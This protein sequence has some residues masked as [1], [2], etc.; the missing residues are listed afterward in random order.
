MVDVRNPVW[1][2]AAL[3]L[4]AL[5]SGCKKKD[6]KPEEVPVPARN[7]A[8]LDVVSTEIGSGL[9][10]R[11]DA[12]PTSVRWE[13]TVVLDDDRAV[14]LG[15]EHDQVWM[16]R[17]ADRGRTWTSAT[18]DVKGWSAWGIAPSGG[19]ALV[20][21]DPTR[22]AAAAGRSVAGAAPPK[23]GPIAAATFWLAGATDRSLDG[24][25]VFFPDDGKLGGVV[26]P[27]ALAA[28][29]A[30]EDG[31]GLLAERNKL[32]TIAY[33][34]RAGTPPDP[35][36][37]DKQAYVPVPYGRP[38]SLL[39]VTRSAVELRPFPR[40]GESLGGATALP[41]YR[42][43]GATFA[44]LSEGPSCEAGAFAFRRLRGAPPWLVGVSGERA[45]AFKLPP[46][47]VAR[48]G[49]ATNAV[50]TET[51]VLDPSDAEKKRKV[52]QLVRCTL[53]GTCAEPK[54]PPF[55]IWSEKHDR[56]IWSVPTSG[57][58]VAV[59]RA[60][61]G[62]RWGLY[63][64]QS[65]DEGAT[66]ELPRTIGE[67]NDTT[68]ALDFGALLRFSNRLVLLISANVGS[69]GRRGW[70]ALASDDEGNHWG[71]P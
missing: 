5:A 57:G 17:T 15:R 1:R 28:P 21:G 19:L 36:V 46:S 47:E 58:L 32:P 29:A 8:T 30:F 35:L 16:L 25:R 24:P 6:D 68:A 23:P 40:P 52:P 13:R 18:A 64:G 60:R 63:L 41:N 38:P 51:T 4:V 65:T 49:C 31:I 34:A 59:M 54:A 55:A 62:G 14:L 2:Y 3:T 22:P 37:L 67:G 11:A 66:F 56:E 27:T 61:T 44:Q 48:L 53:D 10:L 33:A 70:Y 26:V 50:V 43:D 39:S 9:A 12:A 7:A 45:L 42:V 71:P 20:S 69:T